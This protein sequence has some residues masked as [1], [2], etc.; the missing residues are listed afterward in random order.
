MRRQLTLGSADRPANAP[1]AN[2]HP[3]R[4]VTQQLAPSDDPIPEE[5]TMTRQTPTD[6][7]DALEPTADDVA[8]GWDF[9]TTCLGQTNR[10]K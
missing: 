10:T 1:Q 2:S 4:E 3:P 7:L 9:T 5:T 6:P 8:G